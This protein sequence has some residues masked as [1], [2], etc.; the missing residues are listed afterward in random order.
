MIFINCNWKVFH[1][2]PI[3]RTLRAPGQSLTQETRFAFDEQDD[4]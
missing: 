3:I 2:G 1:K 4:I